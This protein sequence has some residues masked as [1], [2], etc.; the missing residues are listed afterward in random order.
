[1][2]IIKTQHALYL[3]QVRWAQGAVQNL[4]QS[5]GPDFWKKVSGDIGGYVYIYVYKFYIYIVVIF[6]FIR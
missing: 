3:S 6:G 2:D 5:Q 4:V 1:M